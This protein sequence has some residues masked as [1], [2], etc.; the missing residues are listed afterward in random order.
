MV[1]KKQ[2]NLSSQ[3]EV[4]AETTEEFLKLED[5]VREKALR[6]CREIT[7]LSALAIKKIHTGDSKDTSLLLDKGLEILKATKKELKSFPE[8]YYAGY[9]HA[10]EKE[11]VEG[12]VTLSLVSGKSL[13]SIEKYGFDTISFLHGMAE[14]VGELRRFLLD[15]MRNGEMEESEKFLQM[16]DEIYFCLRS[17]HYPDGITRSLRRQ[18]DYVR[19]ILDQTRSDVTSA[20]IRRQ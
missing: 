12:I 2:L 4:L 13:P 16:M 1:Q 10:A 8:L 15:K 3:L 14:S 6:N 20:V 9:L 7:R 5:S 17:F 18:V 19:K 11:L